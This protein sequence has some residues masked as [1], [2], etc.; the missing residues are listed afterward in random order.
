MNEP[1]PVGSVLKDCPGGYTLRDLD[2][3]VAL[4]TTNGVPYD[5]AVYV[6]DS[7][8]RGLTAPGLSPQRLV[9]VS[10]DADRWRRDTPGIPKD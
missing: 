4:A 8:W 6:R 9:V 2:A 10:P 1:E 3:L 5:A 7:Q